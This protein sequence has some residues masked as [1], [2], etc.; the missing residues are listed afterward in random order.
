MVKVF[1]K[2]KK[3]IKEGGVKLFLERSFHFFLERKPLLVIFLRPFIIADIKKVSTTNPEDLLAF[4]ERSRFGFLIKPMQI[5]SEFLELLNIF[6]KTNPKVVVEI[7]TANGGTLFCFSKLAAEDALIISIDLPE[8][9]FG[10]GYPESRIPIYNA[11]KKR[12]QS[13]YLLR[14]DS[15]LE[16]TLEKLK[17]ILRGREV[18]FL[19]ID[20]DHT[21]EGVKKDFEMYSSLVKKGGVVAFHDIAPNGDERYTGGVKFFWKEAKLKLPHKEIIFNK[22]QEGFGIGII[23]V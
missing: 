8:G 15:H 18:D 12:N 10:G 5:H 13:L 6:K 21:Y 9:Q 23:Y 4:Q 22:D 16:T 7:G 17:E 3:A 2:T 1:T 11:F 20:G 14:L 19:F